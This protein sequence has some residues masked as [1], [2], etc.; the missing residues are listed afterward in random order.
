MLNIVLEKCLIILSLSLVSCNPSEFPTNS[1]RFDDP[2]TISFLTLVT[3]SFSVIIDF[4]KR[5]MSEIVWLTLHIIIHCFE[6]FSLNSIFLF[7]K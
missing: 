6:E 3:I 1:L 2:K 7:M 4:F 5:T